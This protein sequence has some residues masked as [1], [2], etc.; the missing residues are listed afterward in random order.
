MTTECWTLAKEGL[1][2]GPLVVFASLNSD[3]SGFTSQLG[4]VASFLSASTSLPINDP[5][6]SP[7]FIVE[8]Q[9]GTVG[10]G[11]DLYYAFDL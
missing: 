7:S 11:R 8:T 6:P 4:Q 9:H 10:R 2:I 3:R 1:R 5:N